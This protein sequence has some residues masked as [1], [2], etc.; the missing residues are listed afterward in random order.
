M[1]EVDK[2]CAVGESGDEE[3]GTQLGCLLSGLC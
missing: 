3:G 1:F 2:S